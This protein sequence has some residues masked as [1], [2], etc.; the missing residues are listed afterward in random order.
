MRTIHVILDNVIIHKRRLTLAWPAE[1][2]ARLKLHVLPP[3][4]PAVI[5]IERLWLDPHANVTRNHRA[6]AIAELLERV[7]R[8]LTARFD[9]ERRV[10]GRPDAESWKVIQSS[11]KIDR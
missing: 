3:Y 1:H 5:R 10:L 8:D 6:P 9:I 7:H 2:G 4:C 11:P